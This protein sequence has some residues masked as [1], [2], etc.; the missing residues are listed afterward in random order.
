[1]NKYETWQSRTRQVARN[2]RVGD[3]VRILP[4][5]DYYLNPIE[6]PH[7]P[8][9]HVGVVTG[10]SGEHYASYSIHVEWAPS[11]GNW[12]RKDDLEVLYEQI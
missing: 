2:I 10:L 11:I 12:Y 4:T 7:N 9:G 6:Y 1:M 8:G 3:L 5:S